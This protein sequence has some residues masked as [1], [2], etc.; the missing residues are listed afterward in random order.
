M[1]NKENDKL[2]DEF[3]DTLQEVVVCPYCGDENQ[4]EPAIQCCGEIH[5]EKAYKDEDG[6]I[7]MDS[8]LD[9][10]FAHWLKSRKVSDG[11]HIEHLNHYISSSIGSI[12]K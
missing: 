5:A 1:S 8:E 3:M 6:D 11:E 4:L 7:Y 12:K 9:E 10:L 2:M